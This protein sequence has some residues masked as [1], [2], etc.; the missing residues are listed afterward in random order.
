MDEDNVSKSCEQEERC[1]FQIEV[2]G[3]LDESWSDWFSGLRI[4]TLSGKTVLSGK[5]DQSTLRGVLNKLWD[6]NLMLISVNRE[7]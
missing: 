6:L 3:S 7:E 1:I 4:R 5:M 2:N